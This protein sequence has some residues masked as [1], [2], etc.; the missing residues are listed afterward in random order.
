MAKSAPPSHSSK[1]SPL[2]PRSPVSHLLTF[3]RRISHQETPL[4]RFDVS[5]HTTGVPGRSEQFPP[6]IDELHP[7]D[8][9]ALCKHFVGLVSRLQPLLPASCSWLEPGSIEVVGEHPVD[10]GGVAD[11]RIGKLGNRTVAVK[12]YRYDS[13]SNHSATCAVSATCSC[14]VIPLT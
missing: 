11:I 7:T 14:A 2:R 12:I 5:S 1:L 8:P 9:G 10:A 3:P 4:E 13:S 6:A